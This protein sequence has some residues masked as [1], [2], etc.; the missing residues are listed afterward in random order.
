[1]TAISYLD[2]IDA[3]RLALVVVVILVWLLSGWKE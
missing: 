2:F 1:M 3:G